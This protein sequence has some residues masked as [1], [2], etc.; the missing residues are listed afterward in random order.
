MTSSSSDGYYLIGDL[1]PI[2][3]VFSE[4]VTVNTSAGVPQVL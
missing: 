4:A 1:I 3:I 2:N